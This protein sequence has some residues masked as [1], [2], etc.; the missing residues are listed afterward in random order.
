MQEEWRG[1][2]GFQNYEI[3]N[4]GRVRNA[5]YCRV[6]TPSLNYE[7]Y[8]TIKLFK[9]GVGTNKRVHR[10]V[11]DAFLDNPFGKPQVN[12]IDHDKT[13]NR[14]DNL[15]WVTPQENTD[16]EIRSG[17]NKTRNSKLR[18]NSKY[19]EGKVQLTFLV[20]EE[21]NK[22]LEEMGLRSGLSRARIIR[23]ALHRYL[24]AEEG[25]T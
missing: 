8:L 24:V 25:E 17:T 13:N 2:S 16:H 21:E 5:I 6:L 10:L 14:V 3:S 11:A 1:I 19:R 12:H 20:S 15:E 18:S 22:R 9:D 7:G 4:L 23:E